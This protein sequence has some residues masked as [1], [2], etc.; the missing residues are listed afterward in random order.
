MPNMIVTVSKLFAENKT[1]IAFRNS[2][3]VM[4]LVCGDHPSAY[5]FDGVELNSTDIAKLM[6]FFLDSLESDN[7]EQ[8][9]NLE[10]FEQ[11]Y[12]SGIKKDL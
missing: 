7:V 1:G 2:K 5:P 4:S 11:C 3:G 6:H 12:P 8:K 10:R 9:S